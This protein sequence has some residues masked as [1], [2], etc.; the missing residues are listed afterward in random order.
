MSFINEASEIP[1][2]IV[3]IISLIN[4]ANNYAFNTPH[5]A[6]FLSTL[7]AS[8]ICK[9][10]LS[11]ALMCIGDLIFIFLNIFQ[12]LYNQMLDPHRDLWLVA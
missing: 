8:Q 1:F 2:K 4:T 11:F 9:A 3:T 6:N 12:I 7:D 5:Y 10:V